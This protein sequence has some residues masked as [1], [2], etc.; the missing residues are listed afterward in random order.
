MYGLL[1]KREVMVWILAKFFYLPVYGPRRSIFCVL[2]ASKS[3]HQETFVY[4]KA[5]F[6]VFMKPF[7]LFTQI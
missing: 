3:I 6:A 1:T 7:L 2:K 4:S 5:E